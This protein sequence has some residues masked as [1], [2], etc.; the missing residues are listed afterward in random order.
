M[1]LCLLNWISYVVSFYVLL[2]VLIKL[3]EWWVSIDYSLTFKQNRAATKHKVDYFTTL[4][5]TLFL[6]R[7][8]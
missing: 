7:I 2:I 1:I 3:I 6:S 5:A 8:L 4:P